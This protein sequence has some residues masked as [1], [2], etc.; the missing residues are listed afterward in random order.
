VTTPQDRPAAEA[1][2]VH[3]RPAA[4]VLLALLAL[5]WG[6][7]WVVVK[8]ALAYM[9]PLTYG[10]FRMLGG[11][12]TMVAILGVQRRI[13]LPPRHDLPIVVSVS[14]VQIAAGVLIMNFALQAVPAGRSSVLVYAM[15]LWVALLLWA[16][17]RVRPRRNEA[18]GLVL[19]LGGI[20]VL[21]N[22]TVIDWGVPLE[23]A[24]TLALVV[25]GMLWAA[26]TIHIRRHHWRSRP[27]DL[28]P[29]MLLIATVPI[30]AAAVLLEQGREIRWELPL[31]LA[32]L[33]SGP[34]AT[35]FAN[36]ASQ[37]ITRS[38]GPLASAIGFLATPVVGLAAGAIVLDEPLGLIDLAGFALVLG[39]IAI[40]SLVPPRTPAAPAGI[41]LQGGRTA[42]WTG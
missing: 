20:L 21:V 27:L 13:M 39:G 2:A 29:A 37:S 1:S 5:V 34:L 16:W 10:A 25:N 14:L 19:G 12:L 6:V 8:Q 42:P 9:P 18:V 11:L 32:L 41:G 4:L 40:T 36:W 38:L 23:L 22:P 3:G 17:F 33:Y 30:V 31:V 28:Q 35:A 26:V 24:G 15:P 7:H